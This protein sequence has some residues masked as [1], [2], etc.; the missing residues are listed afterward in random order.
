MFKI[1]AALAVA[2]GGAG[3]GLY[4][5]T[6]LFG[7]SHDCPLSG[8]T[9]G[10]KPAPASAGA[11]CC[12]AREE[13]C[14]VVAPCCSADKAVTARAKPAAG[15]TDAVCCAAK[16]ASAA[17]TALCCADPCLLCAFLACEGCADC[18]LC[19]LGG[20]TNARAAVA[21]PAAVLATK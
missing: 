11:D 8:K 9:C 4:T 17:A 20:A 10:L 18:A 16:P 12:L 2:T 6:D 19:C 1:I 13:C 15:C 7:G 3:Y 21:G 14:D 5:Y